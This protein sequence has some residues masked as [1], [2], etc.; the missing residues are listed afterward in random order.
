MLGVGEFGGGGGG[1]KEV[2]QNKKTSVLREHWPRGM[3]VLFEVNC[4][5]N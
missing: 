3:G 4:H 2:K 5:C 1:E